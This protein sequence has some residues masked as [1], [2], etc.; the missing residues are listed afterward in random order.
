[1]MFAMRSSFV[2]M[3]LGAVLAAGSVLAQKEGPPPGER[4][5]RGP[6]GRMTGTMAGGPGSLVELTRLEEVQK[7]LKLTDDQKEK[8][9]TLAEDVRTKV[10][11]AM[12]ELRDVPPEELKAKQSEFEKKAA[13]AS[14]KAEKQ[15]AEILKPE[16]LARLKE[17]GLQAAGPAALLKPEVAKD[18]GLSDE[19][20][21]NVKKI[22]GE[23][24]EQRQKLLASMR[25]LEPE[26]RMQKMG[27]T[28]EKMNQIQKETGEKAMKVLTAE[29]RD[30]FEK[31]KGKKIDLKFPPMGPRGGR[32][33]QGQPHGNEPP[34]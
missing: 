20:R 12:S 17:I 18:L 11:A 27:E 26:E 29:Q 22:F 10:R 19:Q 30:K 13:E 21:D 34:L 9:K 23:A 6:G 16:Q 32:R 31:M 2:A 25:D 24:R 28:R 5:P 8:L 33:G 1:M 7:E 4:G 15:M 14:Q 3:L